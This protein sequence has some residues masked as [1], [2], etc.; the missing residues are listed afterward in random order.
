MQ[1][2]RLE[3]FM[4]A[5]NEL[6]TEER[7]KMFFKGLSARLVQSAVFS[8]SVILGYETI[9]RIAIQEEYKHRIRW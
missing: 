7:L 4:L 1:V 2:Q 8:F 3:S 9:K 5:A 6:W